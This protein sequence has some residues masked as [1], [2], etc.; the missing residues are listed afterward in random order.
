MKYRPLIILALAALIISVAWLYYPMVRYAFSPK[1]DR[2]NWARRVAERPLVGYQ[3]IYRNLRDDVVDSDQMKLVAVLLGYLEGGLRVESLVPIE[4]SS[5]VEYSRRQYMALL[6]IG[7]GMTMV[8]V[9]DGHIA[10]AV[11]RIIAVQEAFRLY[12][13]IGESFDRN[14][15]DCYG[16]FLKNMDQTIVVNQLAQVSSSCV[17]SLLTNLKA[18]GY[19]VDIDREEREIRA[20]AARYCIMALARQENPTE[21]FKVSTSHVA[22]SILPLA[23]V[24]AMQVNNARPALENERSVSLPFPSGNR[25]VPSE[26]FDKWV[27]DTAGNS[28]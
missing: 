17:K 3:W 12:P 9:P 1:G 11:P 21:V 7:S 18:S 26:V 15:E 28:P 16:R 22:D 23:M 20:M 13:H 19:V 14:V 6:K 4:N 5:K 8:R 10:W 27:R 25:I 24:E 2:F